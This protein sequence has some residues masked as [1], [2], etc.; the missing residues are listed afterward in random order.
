[1]WRPAR[2]CVATVRGRPDGTVS[3]P[4][5]SGAG[6]ASGGSA[7]PTGRLLFG[8]GFLNLNPFV[9]ARAAGSLRA[10]ELCSLVA[11]ANP[12]S[13]PPRARAGEGAPQSQRSEYLRLKQKRTP[14]TSASRRTDGSSSSVH[15][16]AGRLRYSNLNADD[17]WRRTF[18]RY[19]RSQSM[20]EMEAGANGK[21][22]LVPP[23]LISPPIT[24]RNVRTVRTSCREPELMRRDHPA[25]WS[26]GCLVDRCRLFLWPV[27][28]IR[29]PTG[30][31]ARKIGREQIAAPATG[32]RC[33]SPHVPQCHG[34]SRTRARTFAGRA[35]NH[36][37]CQGRASCAIRATEGAVDAVA[38]V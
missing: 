35:S 21:L 15:F 20:G 4:A 24:V 9:H 10:W 11:R 13:P 31:I 6:G 22:S 34:I 7:Y 27:A 17:P 8:W 28:L 2:D 25:H 18:G 16:P 19:G 12:C 14:P 38:K 3:I 5:G 36:R 32:V 1:M 30:D 29:D 23:F 26:G 33:Q 37:F